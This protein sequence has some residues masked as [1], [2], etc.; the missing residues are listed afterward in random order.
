VKLAAKMPVE[1]ERLNDEM[2][3]NKPPASRFAG[4][5]AP[6]Q[7]TVC[8]AL[9][10]P[11]R[12]AEKTIRFTVCPGPASNITPTRSADDPATAAPA[13][14]ASTGSPL[15]AWT[16]PAALNFVRSAPATCRTSDHALALFAT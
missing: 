3:S 4:E 6:T 9:E 2:S 1:P 7:C 13:G 12:S 15:V 16:V 10:L 11:T 8:D 5:S 14:H